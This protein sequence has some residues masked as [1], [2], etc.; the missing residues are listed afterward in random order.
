MPAYCVPAYCACRLIADAGLL[1]MPAYCGCRLIA[2]A[3]LL[4]AGAS[5]LLGLE[6]EA[7]VVLQRGAL[8]LLPAQL[9]RQPRHV[10][11]QLH[12]LLLEA[13]LQQLAPIPPPRK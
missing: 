1:R 12:L 6:L 8:R 5:G 10:L 13:V 3:G 4:R 7:E 2:D 11:L 9:R